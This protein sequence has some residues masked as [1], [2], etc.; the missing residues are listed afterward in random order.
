MLLHNLVKIDLFFLIYVVSLIVD[1]YFVTWNE[2]KVTLL[3]AFT[4]QAHE[5]G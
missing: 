2:A 5:L 1:D 4:S 3:K